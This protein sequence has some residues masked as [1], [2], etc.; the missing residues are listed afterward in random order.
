M[1]GIAILLLL[2]FFLL[3]Y[4]GQRLPQALGIVPNKTRLW[5]LFS[6]MLLALLFHIVL[7]FSIA[8][9][10]QNPYRINPSYGIADFLEALAYVLRSVLYEEL[11][12]RGALLFLLSR[13]AG[14]HMAV[15]LSATAFGIYHWFAW[16]AWGNLPQMLAVFLMTGS[17]GWVLA[18]AY[19]R[20]RTI[21][22][23]FAL[24]LGGNLANTILFSKDA[25]IGGQWLLKSFATDPLAPNAVV[26]LPLLLLHF[27]GFQLLALLFISLISKHGG[28]KDGDPSPI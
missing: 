15:L 28:C 4:F 23:P 20:T 10:V 18:L 3:R 8:G 5:H 21:Y 6:G 24:H 27:A 26:G 16:E 11:L 14:A 9:A 2:S 7:N 25:A 13:K 19:V 17:M 1:I 12:F 22:L